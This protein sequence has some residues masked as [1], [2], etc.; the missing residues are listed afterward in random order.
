M[1]DLPELQ[2]LFVDTITAICSADYDHNQIEAWVS[3]T[4]TGLN[5]QRWQDMMTWQLVLVAQQADK[6]VGFATLDNGRYIDFLFVHKEHQGRGIAQRLLHAIEAEA[7]GLRQTVLTAD[8][9]KTARPFF[10][11]NDFKVL[12]EQMITKKGVSLSNYKMSKAL[13][14]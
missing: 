14:V 11:K 10:E 13:G 3:D 12:T 1:N 9:S 5:Q 8:V 7:K 4:K 2:A 6:I